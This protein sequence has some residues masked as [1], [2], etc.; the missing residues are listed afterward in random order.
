M[1]LLPL[2][3]S[4]LKEEDGK[5]GENKQKKFLAFGKSDLDL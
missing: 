3:P 1:E 5:R 4:R 2:T